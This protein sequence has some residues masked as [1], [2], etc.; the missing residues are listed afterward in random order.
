MNRRSE[1]PSGSRNTCSPNWAL[2][3][4]GIEATFLPVWLRSKEMYRSK[5]R[6]CLSEGRVNEARE[7]FQRCIECTPKMALEVIKVTLLGHS[8]QIWNVHYSHT[9]CKGSSRDGRRRC[10]CSIRSRCSADLSQQDQRGP[11][12]HH[13]GLGLG[14]VWLWKS[15]RALKFTS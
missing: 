7:C 14:T 15:K 9:V 13:R 4:F 11:N 10:G 5:A 2:G 12:C 1:W 8:I 6:Q 3:V